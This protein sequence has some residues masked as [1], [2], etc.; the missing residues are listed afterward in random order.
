M[1]WIQEVMNHQGNERIVILLKIR[2]KFPY[3][4]DKIRQRFVM[5]FTRST[6]E[7]ELKRNERLKKREPGVHLCGR[8]Y[9][10]GGK[11]GRRNSMG[12]LLT[13]K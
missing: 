8:C 5:S 11:M 13:K 7:K 12:K 3:Y 4:E 1:S 6:W 10:K 2:N 9:D